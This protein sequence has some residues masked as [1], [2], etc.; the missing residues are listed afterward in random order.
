[1]NAHSKGLRTVRR[2]AAVAAAFLLLSTAAVVTAAENSFEVFDRR[3]KGEITCKRMQGTWE[4]GLVDEGSG[5]FTSFKQQIATLTKK[6]SK[7]TVKNRTALKAQL[8]T[9]NKNLKPQQRLCAISAPETPTPTPSAGSSPTPKPTATA[10]P[11][12]S[13]SQT[14][15]NSSRNTQ[16]FFIPSSVQGNETR[17]AALYSGCAGCHSE[18]TRRNRTYTQIVA[19]FSSVPQMLPFSSNY[20]TQDFADLAAYLNRYN[21]KQCRT[22]WP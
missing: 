17:G 9:L 14:C 19:A 6:I 12:N 16:C 5:R 7:K 8:N 2:R 21:S 22:D 10:T 3:T 13:C 20:R 15:F 4:P 18:S 1:M 11:G